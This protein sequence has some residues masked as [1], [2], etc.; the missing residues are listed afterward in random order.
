MASVSIVL[1]WTVW[2]S[3][4]RQRR[5][6]PVP[7]LRHTAGRCEALG[8]LAVTLTGYL[9]GFLSGVNHP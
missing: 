9:G 4:L 3:H 7:P 2:Y 6:Q 1:I 5:I 8:I